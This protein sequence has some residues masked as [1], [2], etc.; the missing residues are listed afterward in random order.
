MSDH[1]RLRKVKALAAST[2]IPRERKATLAAVERLEKKIGKKTFTEVRPDFT[3][4]SFQF[5]YQSGMGSNVFAQ[6]MSAQQNRSARANQEALRQQH[7]AYYSDLKRRQGQA[8][9]EILKKAE[10]AYE[11]EKNMSRDDRFMFSAIEASNR[12][13]EIMET[14]KG[15]ALILDQSDEPE[16]FPRSVLRDEGG[17]KWSVPEWI[18]KKKD[19]IS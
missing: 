9:E 1:D 13:G 18:A 19:M 3:T 2:T 11:E 7:E 16:W 6:H 17:T 8:Y 10:A 14:E 12:H 15:K 4:G 5:N